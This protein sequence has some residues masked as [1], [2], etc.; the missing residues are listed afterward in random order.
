MERVGCVIDTWREDEDIAIDFFW[1]RKVTHDWLITSWI[2][3]HTSRCRLIDSWWPTHKKYT[4][5]EYSSWPNFPAHERLH[6]ND[7]VVCGVVWESLEGWFS[8]N[9]LNRSISLR[10]AF[11][12]EQEF[13]YNLIWKTYIFIVITTTILLHHSHFLRHWIFQQHRELFPLLFLDTNTIPSY[14]L[15]NIRF[16]VET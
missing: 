7:S 10:K 9:S 15:L 1:D 14:S 5:S 11:K 16:F 2:L 6:E 4:S 13:N 3:I 12:D 8:L